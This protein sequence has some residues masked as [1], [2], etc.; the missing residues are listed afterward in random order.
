MASAFSTMASRLLLS[1]LV[2]IRLYYFNDARVKQGGGIS[3]IGSISF[4]YFS[5]NTAHDFS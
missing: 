3:Q 1:K 4:R 5:K 2:R